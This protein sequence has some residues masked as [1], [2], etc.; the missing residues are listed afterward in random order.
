MKISRKT[1][2]MIFYFYLIFLIVFV[3]IKFNGSITELSD[4]I[5]SFR[6]LR[7]EG[8][9]NCNFVLFR[10]ISSQIR[11]I[12]SQWA[13]LN[14]LGNTAVFL[15]FGFLLPLSFEKCT[16]FLITLIIC[17]VSVLVIEA[18]QFVTMLGVFDIDDILLNLL[19]GII[20]YVCYIIYKKY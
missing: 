4:R 15:P 8:A 20:G 3:V 19:G 5:S 9:W 1:I 6:Y 13:Y 7:E 12:S 10:T 11:D 2:R 17:A 18:F 14:I 16:K